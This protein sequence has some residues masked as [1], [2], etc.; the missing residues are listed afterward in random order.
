MGK[1][2]LGPKYYNR[3]IPN[4]L[5][6]YWVNLYN[7]IVNLLPDDINIKIADLGCG[8][9]L[10]AEFPYKA[11]YVNYWGVD[12]AIECIKLAKKRVPSYQFIVGNLY[13]KTIQKEFVKYDV[14]IS[15]E[16]LEHMTNDLEVLKA[17]PK[18]KHIIFSV[19]NAGDE[20]HVRCFKKVSQVRERY[21]PLIEFNTELCMPGVRSKK[22][23]IVSGVKK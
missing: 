21:N 20:S 7:E 14:F 9:G 11:G 19:P 17:I 10:F 4:S 15:I 22:F 6:H 12:F 8:P 5:S 13:D 23:F 16:S 18:G 1:K 3:L 2:E